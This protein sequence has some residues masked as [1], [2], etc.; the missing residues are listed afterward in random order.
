MVLEMGKV[1]SRDRM[2]RRY[3]KME[4]TSQDVRIHNGGRKECSWDS[5]VACRKDE[6]MRWREEGGLG[7]VRCCW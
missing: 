7:V 1:D 3:T 6:V 4:W 5:V 2:I